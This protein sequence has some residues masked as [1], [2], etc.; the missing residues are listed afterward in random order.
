M[1]GHTLTKPTSDPPGHK[2]PACP[3]S[4]HRSETSAGVGTRKSCPPRPPGSAVSGRGSGTDGSCWSPQTPRGELPTRS[5]L[6]APTC[7]SGSPAAAGPANPPLGPVKS[8]SLR[9]HGQGFSTERWVWAAPSRGWG[10]GPHKRSA[11]LPHALPTCPC[12]P[13]AVLPPTTGS[14]RGPG[15][16]PA[17]KPEAVSHSVDVLAGGL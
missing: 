3:P 14:G 9:V 4:W 16:A 2:D 1:T 13:P 7:L 11:G 6:D 5:P 10:P 17:T 12:A 15:P 8:C